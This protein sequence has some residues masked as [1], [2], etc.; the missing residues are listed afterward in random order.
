MRTTLRSALLVFVSCLVTALPLMAEKHAP[1]LL[2]VPTVD[3]AYVEKQFGPSFKLDPKFPPMVADL[4][5]DGREDL[6]LVANSPSPLMS[7]SAYNFRVEDPYDRYFGNGDPRITS[8]FD[9]HFDGSSRDILIV[10]GWREPPGKHDSRQ[11]SKFV[12]INT[13]FESLNLAKLRTKKK[14]VQAVEAVDR[15]TLH[16][17]I[18]W[19]GKHWKWAA[20]GMAGDDTIFKMP[21]EK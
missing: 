12:L 16:A 15:S 17:L 2:P 10:M 7:Q 6:V 20:Q 3:A 14:N 13:P 18:F 1:A 5:G 11:V 9:L 21:S 4:E 8:Q 19:D